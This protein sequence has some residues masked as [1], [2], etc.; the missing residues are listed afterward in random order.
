MPRM[1]S[2][3]TVPFHSDKGSNA[4]EAMDPGL[5]LSGNAPFSALAAGFSWYV[6]L[7]SIFSLQRGLWEKMDFAAGGFG[8]TGSWYHVAHKISHPQSMRSG[9]NHFAQRVPRAESGAWSRDPGPEANSSVTRHQVSGPERRVPERACCSA[10]H[11]RQH[12]YHT[13]TSERRL[14]RFVRA[15]ALP[16]NGQ[17]QTFLPEEDSA[18]RMAFSNTR[19][20]LPSRPPPPPTGFCQ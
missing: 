4:H 13:A 2:G 3:R 14:R 20:H 19:R 8:P 9:G 17:G 10:L 16:G 11:Q 18:T 1:R 5:C 12:P 7:R 6:P 15:T